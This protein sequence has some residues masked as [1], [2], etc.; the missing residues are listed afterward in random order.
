M[1]PPK[2][3]NVAYEY[4][5]FLSNPPSSKL[6]TLFINISINKTQDINPPEKAKPDA[7]TLFD[8]RLTRDK[9]YSI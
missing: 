8:A 1:T 4:A 9:K 6:D 2:K 5:N 7:N 3:D